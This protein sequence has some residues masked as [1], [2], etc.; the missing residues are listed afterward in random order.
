MK[1]RRPTGKAPAAAW[2]PRRET[3]KP[4]PGLSRA[5]WGLAG[6]AALLL[7]M[8]MLSGRLRSSHSAEESLAPAAEAGD[9]GGGSGTGNYQAAGGAVGEEGARGGGSGSDNEN[10]ID[11]H[12]GVET[13]ADDVHP[14][15]SGGGPPASGDLEG[16]EVGASGKQTSAISGGEAGEEEMNGNTAPASEETAASQETTGGD[17]GYLRSRD[18]GEAM[19]DLGGSLIKVALSLGVVVLLVLATRFFLKRSRARVEGGGDTYLKVLGYT[20]LGNGTGVHEVQVGERVWFIGEGERELR[21]LGEFDLSELE[22]SRLVKEAGDEGGFAR[23][24][25]GNLEAGS[26][27]WRGTVSRGWLNA[28][29]WKTAR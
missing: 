11:G 7:V 24:L 25:E 18:D 27:E 29:R 2:S 20:R 12:I 28:L 4:K 17:G 23:E 3:R 8:S 6:L 26:G 1:T 22:L 16:G 21:L 15:L 10:G 19:P 5:L 14:G 13:A 9:T